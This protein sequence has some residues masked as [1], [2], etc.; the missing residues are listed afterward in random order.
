MMEIIGQILALD[1]VSILEAMLMVIGGAATIAAMTP[2][3][4]DDGILAKM[5]GVLDFVAMNVLKAKNKE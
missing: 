5:K 2:T 4:K 3:P 1:W